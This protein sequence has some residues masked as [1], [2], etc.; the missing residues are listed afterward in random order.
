[1]PNQD[2]TGPCGQGPLTGRMAGPCAVRKDESATESAPGALRIRGNGLRRGG[3][4]RRG[5]LG[6]F[7]G[8]DQNR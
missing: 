6:R 8:R 3:F 1:M 4:L 7:M 2:G 5:F